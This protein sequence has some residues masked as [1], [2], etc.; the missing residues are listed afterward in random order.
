[1][2][3]IVEVDPAGPADGRLWGRRGRNEGWCLNSRTK[4]IATGY[5][6]PRW[7]KAG[8]TD[9]GRSGAP[10]LNSRNQPQP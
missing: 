9:V 8:E 6:S 4:A 1:M 3:K 2:K 7:G 5:R 10:Y